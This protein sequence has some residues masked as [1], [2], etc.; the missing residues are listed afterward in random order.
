MDFRV[1]K[2]INLLKFQP[3]L[4]CIEILEK[5]SVLQ[6][7]NYLKR[8]DYLYIKKLGPSYFFKKN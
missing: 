2:S 4:I 1:L 7:K 8:L 5:K 6:V 3:S